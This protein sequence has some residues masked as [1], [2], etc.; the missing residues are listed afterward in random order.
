MAFRVMRQK[1][2]QRRNAKLNEIFDVCKHRKNASKNFL[3]FSQDKD[4]NE[5]GF[6]TVNHVVDIFKLYQV[7][8][9]IC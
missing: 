9:P 7:T 3:C 8:R 2:E 5:T 1:R 4:P 6:I